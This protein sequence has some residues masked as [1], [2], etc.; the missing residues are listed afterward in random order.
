[1]PTFGEGQRYEKNKTITPQLK[2]NKEQ[3]KLSLENAI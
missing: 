2:G 3:S 1:M